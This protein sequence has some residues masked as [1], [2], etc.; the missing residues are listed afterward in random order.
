MWPFNSTGRPWRWLLSAV[1]GPLAAW[2]NKW[3]ALFDNL[4]LLANP[5]WTADAD[6]NAAALSVPLALIASYTLEARSR[7]WLL[8]A[9]IGSLI[10]AALMGISCFVLRLYLLGPPYYPAIDDMLEQVWELFY[11]LMIVS[12]IMA[13]TFAVLHYS[14]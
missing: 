6:L 7:D 8:K 4:T 13:I 3:L 10:F 9:V 1:P 12:I 2:A 5:S 14:R 11:V